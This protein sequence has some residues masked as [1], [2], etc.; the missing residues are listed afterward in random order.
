VVYKD[1][2][3]YKDIV[4]ALVVVSEKSDS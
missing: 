2:V 1:I 3:L 4:I